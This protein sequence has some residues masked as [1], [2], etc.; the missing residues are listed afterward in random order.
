MDVAAAVDGEREVVMG[1]RQQWKGGIG[2]RESVVVESIHLQWSATHQ[3]LHYAGLPG[4]SKAF[5]LSDS[6]YRTSVELDM[7]SLC[8]ICKMVGL[9]FCQSLGKQY[10]ALA[11]L[12]VAMQIG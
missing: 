7:K 11:P 4:I 1:L 8:S 5:F 2:R 10:P 3:Y 12:C 6:F 9:F